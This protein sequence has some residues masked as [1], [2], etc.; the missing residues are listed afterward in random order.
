[1]FERAL[2]LCAHAF[3]AGRPCHFCKEIRT[4][5]LQRLTPDRCAS[6]MHA[7]LQ[8][9]QQNVKVE[10]RF[11]TVHDS[12]QHRQAQVSS[13]PLKAMREVNGGVG[14][15]SIG[16]QTEHCLN[17]LAVVT[18]QLVRMDACSG[19]QGHGLGLHLNSSPWPMQNGV[20]VRALG[21][22][23][24]RSTLLC[25]NLTQVVPGGFQQG[26]GFAAMDAGKPN[27]FDSEMCNA[28]SHGA[29][30]PTA[31]APS[32]LRWVTGTSTTAMHL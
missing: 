20:A 19:K 26:A 27:A 10:R 15:G 11:I 31:A 8:R 23:A 25:L 24:A 4:Q 21:V 3:Q 7:L 5:S 12:T 6:N 17:G 18:A 13:Q 29:P 16:R 32:S 2:H 9:Q 22:Y 14:N 1:M 30:K 28:F